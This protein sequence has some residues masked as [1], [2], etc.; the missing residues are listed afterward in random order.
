MYE[1]TLFSH[2]TPCSL[3]DCNNDTRS[4]NTLKF[5]KKTRVTST[6]TSGAIWHMCNATGVGGRQHSK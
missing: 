6:D 3:V 1:I 2:V 4:R 5:N